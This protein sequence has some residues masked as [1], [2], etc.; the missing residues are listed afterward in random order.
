M[1]FDVSPLEVVTL[2]VAAVFIFG[3]EKLP[4]MISETM[5]VLRKFRDFSESAKQDIRKELGPGFEEFDF[6]DLNPKAFVRKQLTAPGNDYGQSDIQGLR[7][8][9]AENTREITASV[10]ALHAHTPSSTG[11]RP[12][13]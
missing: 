11:D 2:A 6:Q 5:R 13:T 10:Q 12:T 4:K 9:I 8:D 7:H 1:I 3:P